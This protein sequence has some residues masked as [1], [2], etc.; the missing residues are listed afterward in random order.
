MSGLT[1]DFIS[2]LIWGLG[3]LEVKLDDWY[4]EE[5]KSL[6]EAEIKGFECCL[7]RIEDESYKIKNDVMYK[8]LDENKK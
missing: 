3:Q 2:G 5:R 4:E 6:N 1:I 8:W 7:D